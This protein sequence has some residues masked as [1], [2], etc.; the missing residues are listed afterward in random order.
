MPIQLRRVL[1]GEPHGDYNFLKYPD[2]TAPEL[3]PYPAGVYEKIVSD[4]GWQQYGNYGEFYGGVYSLH[5]RFLRVQYD[6][7]SMDTDVNHMA[8]ASLLPVIARFGLGA[9]PQISGNVKYV[10][11][12]PNAVVDIAPTGPGYYQ[13]SYPTSQWRWRFAVAIEETGGTLDLDELRAWE[14]LDIEN[15]LEELFPY[16]IETEVFQLPVGRYFA[17]SHYRVD[18]KRI[19]LTLLV[20][21]SHAMFRKQLEEIITP[22]GAAHPLELF[23]DDYLF[24]CAV[25]DFRQE[26]LSGAVLRYII[27]LQMVQPHGYHQN[28]QQNYIWY[29]IL[30][31]SLSIDNPATVETPCEVRLSID[32]ADTPAFVEIYVQPL[33]R[34]VRFQPLSGVTGRQLYSIQEDG[35]LLSCAQGSAVTVHDITSRIDITRSRLPLMLTP[36]GN[37]VTVVFKDSNNQDITG[38]SYTVDLNVTYNPRTDLVS[39][40]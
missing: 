5:L 2:K 31:L 24:R 11:G 38:T 8:N 1:V 27:E 40:L 12:K 7:G 19:M 30:P 33:N 13:L 22:K 4:A 32:A 28:R 21:Q 37:M 14:Y 36:G 3:T 35:R 15:Y 39:L 6:G 20:P 23:I 25:A 10:L 9:F 34:Y 26:W 16:S 17:G 29:T 18:A